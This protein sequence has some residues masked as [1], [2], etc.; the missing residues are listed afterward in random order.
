MA[1][2]FTAVQEELAS[3]GLSLGSDGLSHQ[4]SILNGE[5]STNETSKTLFKDF[6]GIGIPESSGGDGGSLVD[7]VV[8]IE[9]LARK[10]EPTSYVIHMAAVQVALGAGLNVSPAVAGNEIWTLGLSEKPG[11]RWG[12][13]EC[14]ISKEVVS[15]V[16]IG[17]PYAQNCQGVVIA[18]AKNDV[19]LVDQFSA[20]ERA[21][22]DPSLQFCDVAIS[23]KPR[24]IGKETQLP[25]LRGALVVSAELIGVARGAMQSASEYAASRQQFGQFIGSFQG[26]AHLLADAFVEVEAA[27]S[28]V[29]YAAWAVEESESDAVVC[30][31]SAIAKAGAAA[32]EVTEKCLQVFGG[33]GVTWEANSH[34]YIRRVLAL[35]AV[36]GGYSNHYRLTGQQLLADR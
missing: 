36:L 12:E 3:I 4:R 8:F 10:V 28:L 25:L 27:W 2:I 5:A 15:V 16:K 7:L 14:S 29:L 31:H 34:L 20:T 18:G 1:A 35:N 9:S 13:W 30:S 23:G 32:I 11:Q 21:S 22:L 17:V 19:A 6:R 26:I 24:E 33:I